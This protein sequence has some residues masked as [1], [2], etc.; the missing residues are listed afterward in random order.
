[1]IHPVQI[2]VYNRVIGVYHSVAVYMYDY[3]HISPWNGCFVLK[4]VAGSKQYSDADI[5]RHHNRS[6]SGQPTPVS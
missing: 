5:G 2:A 4:P 6:D 1:M 3:Y